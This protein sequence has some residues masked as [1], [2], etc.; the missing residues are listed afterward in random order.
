MD[1]GNFLVEL[2]KASTLISWDDGAG[3]GVWHLVSGVGGTSSGEL[4]SVDSNSYGVPMYC[5]GCSSGFIV[6][7]FSE[8][9][10]PVLLASLCPT[11]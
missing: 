2:A 1:R 9:D 4:W 7:P 11:Y 10:C 3:C 6:S 5:L 8:P